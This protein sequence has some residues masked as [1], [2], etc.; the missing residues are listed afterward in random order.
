MPIFLQKILVLVSPIGKAMQLF[1]K[2]QGAK[3]GRKIQGRQG[4]AAQL[5]TVVTGYPARSENAHA[6]FNIGVFCLFLHNTN[7]WFGRL[8]VIIKF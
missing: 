1:Y 6:V 3:I 4:R 5:Q 2:V 8:D 7:G